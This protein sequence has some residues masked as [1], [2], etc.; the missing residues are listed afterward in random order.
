M[1]SDEEEVCDYFYDDDDAEEDA[2]AGLEEDSPPP[3]P[4]GADYWVSNPTRTPGW[5]IV[6]CLP[7]W[8]SLAGEIWEGL[9]DRF[10]SRPAYP[11]SP[12]LYLI[13]QESK[14]GVTLCY[15]QPLRFMLCY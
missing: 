1:A 13:S 10:D 5:M 2:A 14:G 9:A 4:E 6:V 12:V 15:S 8:D 11:D 3:P 7:G